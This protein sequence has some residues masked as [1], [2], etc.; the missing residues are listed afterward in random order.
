MFCYQVFAIK[1]LQEVDLVTRH[2]SPLFDIDHQ[3][4]LGGTVVT[5]WFLC[6]EKEEGRSDN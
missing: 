6:M 3:H 5:V 4:D 2:S 1:Y